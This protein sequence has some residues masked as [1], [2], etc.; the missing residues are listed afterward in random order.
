MPYG[1]RFVTYSQNLGSRFDWFVPDC[2]MPE[3]SNKRGYK[4]NQSIIETPFGN[5]F[6][7][8]M[9]KRK[10]WSLQFRDIT[11]LSKDRLEHCYC[12]WLGSR[13]ITMEL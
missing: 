6:I 8:D 2:D 3:S 7:Y 10:K 11:T 13:Q 5:T 9:G 4:V 1:L 12:G